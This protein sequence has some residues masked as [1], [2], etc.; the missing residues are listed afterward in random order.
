MKPVL[1]GRREGAGLIQDSEAIEAFAQSS[2]ADGNAAWPGFVES[3][4]KWV[5][6]RDEQVVPAA[7]SDDADAYSSILDTVSQPA[8]DDFVLK[9]A[10]IAYEL[11][12][13]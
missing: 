5:E 6:L 9:W 11:D 2:G 12:S 13:K 3:Y 1:L 4:Q 7:L 8:I 10:E